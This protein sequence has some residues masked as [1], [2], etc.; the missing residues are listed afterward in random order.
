MA[1]IVT[2]V[3][4]QSSNST[5]WSARSARQLRR[6]AVPVMTLVTVCS[7]T[8]VISSRLAAGDTISSDKAKAA[9]IE[10]ELSAAQARMSALGQQYDAAAARLSQI[11]TNISNTKAAILADHKQVGVDRETLSKA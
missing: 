11:N 8:V 3:E 1:P 5:P 6:V 7:C 2:D 9:A 4:R 10:Q